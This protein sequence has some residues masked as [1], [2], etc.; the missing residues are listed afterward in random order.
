MAH[1]NRT[2]IDDCSSTKYK[3][4]VDGIF[5]CIDKCPDNY[6]VD[7]YKCVISCG[8]ENF[9]KYDSTLKLYKCVTGCGTSEYTIENNKTCVQKCDGDYPFYKADGKK[10]L[11]DCDYSL[12]DGECKDKCDTYD[13]KEF[14][15]YNYENK[16]CL[17]EC[18]IYAMAVSNDKPEYTYYHYQCFSKC[19]ENAPY[20]NGTICSSSCSPSFINFTT[21]EC[22][23]E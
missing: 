12:P 2:C 20:L 9:Y 21:Y 16:T 17:E 15:Y 10:C 4:Y 7:N 23:S 13:G 3:Y 1:D 5:Y 22:Q 18:P 8:N 11:S 6:F 14:I 19:P